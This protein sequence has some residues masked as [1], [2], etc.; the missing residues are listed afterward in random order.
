MNFGPAIFGALKGGETVLGDTVNLA[1]RLQ[2]LAEPDA[3]VMSRAMYL[4]L[5]AWIE[6]TD[7]GEHDVKGRSGLERIFR[8]RDI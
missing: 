1:A 7:L 3:V 4:Q 6:A 8:L 5:Q 2:S